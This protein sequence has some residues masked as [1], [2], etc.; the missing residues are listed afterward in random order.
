LPYPWKNPVTAPAKPIPHP[1]EG[2]FGPGANQFG[3]TRLGENDDFSLILGGPLYRLFCRAHLCGKIL[4][5]LHRRVLVILGVA[6]FPLLLFSVLEGNAW[7]SGIKVPFL[8]DIEVYARFLVAIPLLVLA[9]LVIHERMRPVV[10]QFFERN[11][12]PDSA[13]EKFR[14]AIDSAMRLRN[15]VRAEVSLIAIV[16]AL[17]VFLVWHGDS[18]LEVSSW[19]GPFFRGEFH[20][21]LAGWW[22]RCVSLPAL[23]FILLRWYYRVFIWFRFLWQISRLDLKLMATH[24]DRSAGLGFLTLISYAFTPLLFAQGALVAG[25]IADRIF[26]GGAKL[27]QFKVEIGA[28]V[29]IAVLMV[30]GPLLA[31]ARPLARI[32]RKALREYGS[33]AQRYVH[34]FDEKWVRGG[35][36]AGENLLGSSDIQSLADLSNSFENVTQ[37]K[38]VPFTVRA[39][40]RLVMA[41]LIPIAPLIL[42]M[43]PAEELAQ[44]VLKMLF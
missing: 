12:V 7:G 3:T 43:I 13:R 18:V 42:T 27:P 44:R 20:P 21:T 31:F 5:Q 11:L 29:V 15:S 19:H 16:Y 32:K 14:A 34:E 9:E 35:A 41:A 30:V 37:M 17:G 6:W 10:H 38:L 22:F 28:L 1:S 33:L 23:Q 26:F 24:P 39:L 40:V 8:M 4:E 25:V 36:P 2:F